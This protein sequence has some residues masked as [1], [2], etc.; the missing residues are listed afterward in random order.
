MNGQVENK[1]NARKEFQAQ[2]DNLVQGVRRG[3]SS[4]WNWEWVETG[5]IFSLY[6]TA[7]IEFHQTAE[8]FSAGRNYDSIVRGLYTAGAA[9]YGVLRTFQLNAERN[10]F[11]AENHELREQLQDSRSRGRN[12][13][14]VTR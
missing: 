2:F 3:A 6:G 9:V 11:R 1:P 5:S 8:A 4:I 7:A 13:F 14:K 10:R 12:R